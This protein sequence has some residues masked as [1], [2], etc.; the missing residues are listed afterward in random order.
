MTTMVMASPEIVLLV[1]GGEIKNSI[2]LTD[3]IRLLYLGK[4][5]IL[6]AHDGL[7]IRSS[8]GVDVWPMPKILQLIRT[9]ALNREKIYGP[10]MV[11]KRG[12]LDRDNR[13]CA[14]CGVTHANT[15]DHVLPRSKGGES[16]WLNLVAACRDCNNRKR[17]RTPEEAGMPLTVKP[18][19]PK[20]KI[21]EFLS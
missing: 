21:A 1:N 18:Y 19:A 3:A 8:S 9:V 20:R 6:E 12:V 2:G 17:N 16:S 5:E 10:R 14:Y 15:V 13:T 7:F 11:S 4:V